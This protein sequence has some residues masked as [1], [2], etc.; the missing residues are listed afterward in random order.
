VSREGL[1]LTA[2]LVL[3]ASEFEMGI[4]GALGGAAALALGLFAGVWTDR[5]RRRPILIAADLGRAA[6]LGT[7]PLAAALGRLTFAH[8]GVAVAVAGALTVFFDVAYQAYVPELVERE[9][10]I[11]ANSKLAASASVAEIAG[12]PL[13]GALVQWITAPVAI[14]VDAVSF[15]FSAASLSLIGRREPTPARGERGRIGPEIAEG[16]R[17]VWRDP[18]LRALAARTATAAFFL[19]FPASLYVLFAIR[20]LGLKPATLGAVVAVGGVTSLLGASAAE[21]ITRR[22]GIGPSL[23]AASL[24][25]GAGAL[26]VPMARGSAAVAFLIAAQLTDFA[27]TVYTVADTSLRQYRAPERLLGRVN[28]AMLLLFR[29]GLPVGALAAGAVASGLGVRTALYVGAAG[30]LLSPV[31]L[32]L[33]PVVQVRGLERASRND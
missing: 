23:I 19:G 22:L 33:S 8:L 6:V 17:A 31:W 3:G 9:R 2:V 15:L 10:L 7:I 5:L 29:G 16:L 25:S 28:A 1:P 18:V 13:T 27:W 21:R 32:V 26:L 20:E 12:P 24:I 11:E 14:L 30:V 4:L